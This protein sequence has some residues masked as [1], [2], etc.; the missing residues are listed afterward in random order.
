M[1]YTLDRFPEKQRRGLTELLQDS[2]QVVTFTRNLGGL[3]MRHE[4]QKRKHTEAKKAMVA[5]VTQA[6]QLVPEEERPDLW[7]KFLGKALKWVGKKLVK[8]VVK[9]VL[10]FA[11]RVA[12]QLLRFAV[13]ALL[14]Y[15]IIPIIQFVVALAVAN[16]ISAAVIGVATLLGGGYLAWKKWFQ[17]P[18]EKALVEVDTTNVAQQATDIQSGAVVVGQEAQTS[19]VYETRAADYVTKARSFFSGGPKPTGKFKGFGA[20]VD[21][22]I[23][24]ASQ[25]YPILPEDAFRGFVK[26]EAGWTGAM[27]PT[28]AIG[29]GQF[30]QR[31]WD[32]LARTPEGRAIGMTVIGNRFRTAEDPRF[33]KRVNT[34]AT[35]LLASQNAQM[36]QRAGLPITGENLY[37]MHNIGP[38]IIPVMKGQP[39][40]AQTLDAM[41]KN[42]MTGNMTAQQFLDFQKGRFR[43]AYADANSSTAMQGQDPQMARGIAVENPQA[44]AETK[45]GTQTTP[46]AS[47]QQQATDLVRGPGRTIVRA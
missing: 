16:P 5:F 10:R 47:S 23:K 22:Y 35:G 36:L 29:T 38:G 11:G 19:Q 9:S 18:D 41:R 20:D 42:G 24:E 12:M 26:M 8:T 4:Q 27:S 39:A 34:L 28:G 43:Q 44:A 2:I 30:V 6:N 21:A 25:R 14:T 40:S 1:N 33:D 37:M 17:K 3:L 15:V 45:T 13:R 7:S 46:V 32:A 31:T